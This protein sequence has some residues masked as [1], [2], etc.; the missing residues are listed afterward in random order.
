MRYLRAHLHEVS[1]ACIPQRIVPHPLRHA[2]ASQMLRSVV[3]FP[4]IMKPLDHTSPEMIMLYLDIALTDLEREL[5]LAHSQP[6][7][8]VPQ[9]KTQA[10]SGAD[11]AGIV[12]SLLHAQHMGFLPL[13]RVG[14]GGRVGCEAGSNAVSRRQW[15]LGTASVWRKAVC[16]C[17]HETDKAHRPAFRLAA[18][19]NDPLSAQ[20]HL[21][22]DELLGIAN[23]R[24]RR[25][26]AVQRRR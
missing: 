3:P 26:Y 22:L 1:A 16:W 9:P 20:A 6:R 7:H 2:Y 18:R 23:S 24:F 11:L 15:P 21:R 13:R 12:Q 19:R 10:P 4:A 14:S 5:Q 8:L 17:H 25:P